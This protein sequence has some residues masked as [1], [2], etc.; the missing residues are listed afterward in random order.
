RAAS[1]AV[2]R[3]GGQGRRAS[4]SCC[5]S[6]CPIDEQQQVAGYFWWGARHWPHRSG[7]GSPLVVARRPFVSDSVPV[8]RDW[9]PD[10]AR[11]K[12]LGKD[13]PSS[14]RRYQKAA[15]AEPLTGNG[16]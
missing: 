14:G 9:L 16:A 8:V 4:A 1:P 3:G 7:R 13:K 11:A 2:A 5:A 10:Q 12:K 15:L 6:T